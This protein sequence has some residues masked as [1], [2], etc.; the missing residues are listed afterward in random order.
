MGNAL[1]RILP[2]HSD[3][4]TELQYSNY[5]H[6]SAPLNGEGNFKPSGHDPAKARIYSILIAMSVVFL[7][8]NVIQV[9]LI[10]TIHN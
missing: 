9:V 2:K 3:N 8:L 10:Y 6:D 1:S 7:V 5:Y 4:G